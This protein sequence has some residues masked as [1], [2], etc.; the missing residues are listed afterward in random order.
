MKNKI[1]VHLLVPEIDESYDVFI[2]IN[3]RIGTVVKLLNKSIL[4][5]TNGIFQEKNSRKLYSVVDSTTYPTNA[6]VRETNIRN[7]VTVILM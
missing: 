2:P 5:L 4:E 7:G 3:I 1:L 6:L